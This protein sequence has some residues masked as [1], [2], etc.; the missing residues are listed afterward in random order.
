MLKSRT[1][2]DKLNDPRTNEPLNPTQNTELL[3]ESILF[4]LTRVLNTRQG[5]PLI[6]PQDYGM[7]D[8]TEI[9]TRFPDSITDVQKA[10]RTTIEKYEPRL[11]N[12]QVEHIGEGAD[13]QTLKFKITAQLADKKGRDSVYFETVI[14]PTGEVQVNG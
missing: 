2:F 14:D 8:I 3:A 9:S 4:H 11:K 10:I 12:V 1:L 6:Q 13:L 7:V 5:G